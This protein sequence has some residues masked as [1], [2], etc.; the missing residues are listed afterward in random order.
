MLWGCWESQLNR[1]FKMGVE[2]LFL[3]FPPKSP[4]S[5]SHRENYVLF[6]FPLDLKEMVG[7]ELNRSRSKFSPCD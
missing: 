6:E 4:F 3:Q 1:T 2:V 5:P 7:S